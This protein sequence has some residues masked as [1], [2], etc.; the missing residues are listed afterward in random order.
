MSQPVPLQGG[1]DRVA[2]TPEDR[3]WEKANHHLP[4]LRHGLIARPYNRVQGADISLKHRRHK[5][6]RFE[7]LV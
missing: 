1:T 5:A 4:P 6:M 7:K 2:L 3:A